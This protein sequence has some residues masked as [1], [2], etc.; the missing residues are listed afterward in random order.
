MSA[1][2][3]VA[4]VVEA[5]HRLF[6]RHAHVEADDNPRIGPR[7]AVRPTHAGSEHLEAGVSDARQLGHAVVPGSEV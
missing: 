5:I 2:A 6:A 1:V 4:A 7:S 3:V